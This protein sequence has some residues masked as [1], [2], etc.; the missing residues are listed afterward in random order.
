[1]AALL[2]LETVEAHRRKSLATAVCHA[3]ALAVGYG[4]AGNNVRPHHHRSAPRACLVDPRAQLA[5][6]HPGA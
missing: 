1:M 4:E 6:A 3:F 2:L 5:S